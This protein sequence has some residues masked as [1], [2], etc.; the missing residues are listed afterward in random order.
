M[1]QPP[2]KQLQ[3]ILLGK[4]LCTPRDLKRCVRR[5]KRLAADLPAFD[6]V[7]LD[8]L[9]Q[10]RTLTSFQAQAIESDR[11]ELL[12]IGPGIVLDQIGAGPAGV[13]YLVRIP[14]SQV[15]AV[16]KRIPVAT[17]LKAGTLARFRELSQRAISV[18]QAGVVVPHA[19]HEIARS[20]ESRRPAAKAEKGVSPSRRRRSVESANDLLGELAVASRLVEGL[21]LR[22]MLL[23]RG[24]FPAPVVQ[25]I[26]R[27]LLESLSALGSAGIVHG[28]VLAGN[29]I[30]DSKARAIL[31]DAGVR[32]CVQPVFSF[33]AT[34]DPQCYSGIAPELIGTGQARSHRSDLYAL[35]CLLW[36]LLAARPV[37]PTGDPLARLALHQ[38]DR[39]PDVREIA[40]D[41]PDSL[42][43]AILWL[44][45]PDPERRPWSAAEVLGRTSG[46]SRR[47]PA[48]PDQARA[49]EVAPSG[50]SPAGLVEASSGNRGGLQRATLVRSS[51]RSLAGFSSGFSRRPARR[52]NPSSG[53][54]RFAG[55]IAVAGL[56]VAIASASLFT[57]HGQPRDWVVAAIAASAGRSGSGDAGS[58]AVDGGQVSVAQAENN[59][60][61]SASA[62]AREFP[63]P[64]AYGLLELAEVGPWQAESLLWNGQRLTIRGTGASPSVVLI[65]RPVRFRASEIVVENVEFVFQTPEAVSQSVAEIASVDGSIG[66][67]RSTVAGGAA[68]PT[69]AAL[70]FESQALSVSDGAFLSED[71]NFSS[72]L[73]AQDGAGAGGQSA[74]M[75]APFAFFWMPSNPRDSLPGEIRIQ[76]TRL[77][78]RR[79]SIGLD[80]V[81][82]LVSCQN[83]LQSGPGPLFIIAQSRVPGRHEF[84]LKHCTLRESG[85]L[86]EA[87]LNDGSGW[88]S[89]VRIH[90][91]GCVFDL[92]SGRTGEPGALVR[93]RADSLTPAWPETLLI[94]GSDSIAR[95]DLKLVEGVSRDGRYRRNL[96]ASSVTLNGL[97]GA[98][99][100]FQSIE[101]RP[102]FASSFLKRHDASLGAAIR[103]GIDGGTGS[104]D[105]ASHEPAQMTVPEAETFYESEAKR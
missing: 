92:S 95:P 67:S 71:E 42:A 28:E 53:R 4:K 30:V 64:D 55:H 11:T 78:G 75:P 10:T 98:S 52:A 38:T 66:T 6:S 103:P 20:V 50:V 12:T 65:D 88:R 1:V 8:A 77:I 46:N 21:T 94:N 102:D 45:E 76:N 16:I 99:F 68:R 19:C 47:S 51:H 39:V 97:I 63:P 74:S 56:A 93:F 101:V 43:E 69:V 80:G 91:V 2:S 40:P 86:V 81:R 35:G 72:E 33:S 23:R 3:Q 32:P 73:S 59:F 58:P 9:V 26:A 36:E 85:G 13:T 31:V 37:F 41:T 62:D 83:V 34:I 15:P 105:S 87:W 14:E 27:Q 96:D 57:L 104:T 7:W 17:E 90:P 22:Q 70:R 61:R 60:A 89:Q 18:G 49:S 54:N 5:V 25:E 44:T 48:N 24:R 100:E 29:V 79:S 84:H 82:Y